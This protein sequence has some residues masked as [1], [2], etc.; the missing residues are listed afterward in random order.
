[1]ENIQNQTGLDE[2][3]IIRAAIEACLEY[4]E[5]HGEITLPLSV[6]PKSKREPQPIRYRAT[7]VSA[8]PLND[9]PNK[10]SK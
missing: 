7:E 1:L 9:P 4:V 2:S 3:T 8:V 5:A 6:M 10:K